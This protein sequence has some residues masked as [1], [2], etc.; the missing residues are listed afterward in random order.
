[1]S[2]RNI[3]EDSESV[4]STIGRVQ[5]DTGAPDSAALPKTQYRPRRQATL[6]DAV[7]G[8]LPAPYAVDH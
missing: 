8:L 4:A 5:S 7:A 2:E 3:D 6:Y 1:M